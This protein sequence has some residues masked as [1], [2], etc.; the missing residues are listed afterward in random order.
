MLENI[1]DFVGLIF[2]VFKIF[3]GI[4]SEYA[5]IISAICGSIMV[6]LVGIRMGIRWLF[7]R[8]EYKAAIER[9]LIQLERFISL[10][11]GKFGVTKL[12]DYYQIKVEKIGNDLD[13]MLGKID[14]KVIR[15]KK[16]I[17]NTLY[18]IV[19][20]IM[21]LSSRRLRETSSSVMNENLKNHQIQ[22][23]KED[24]MVLIKKI[25]KIV[26]KLDQ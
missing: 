9:I 5:I 25:K 6:F 3:W 11:E 1:T 24:G 12:D 18:T 22:T 14:V 8:R 23:R 26:K 16:D 2:S 20:E 21:T 10:E 7:R 17:L 15:I 4:I 13:E 19:D